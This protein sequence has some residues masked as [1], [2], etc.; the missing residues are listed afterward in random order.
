MKIGRSEEDC[1][2]RHSAFAGVKRKEKRVDGKRGACIF[3]VWGNYTSWF[4]QKLSLKLW[5]CF[6]RKQTELQEGLCN[7]PN[8]KLGINIVGVVKTV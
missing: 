3:Y 2:R 7:C 8:K 1:F 5:L 4:E 6:W